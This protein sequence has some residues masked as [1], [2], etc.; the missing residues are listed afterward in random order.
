[1]KISISKLKAIILFFGNHTNTK[2]LGKVKLMKLFYFIN[3]IF[4]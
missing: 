4:D 3:D 1:M 2:F